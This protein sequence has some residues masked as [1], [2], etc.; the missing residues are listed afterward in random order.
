MAGEAVRQPRRDVASRVA[1]GLLA[2]GALLPLAAAAQSQPAEVTIIT[3]TGT[4]V[5]SGSQFLEESG[6]LRFSHS[7]LSAK[8]IV[9]GNTPPP[10]DLTG[11][12]HMPPSLYWHRYAVTQEQEREKQ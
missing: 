11:W 10:R 3:G 2:V 9:D 5:V 1:W 8:I 12:M 6:P 4:E 7:P